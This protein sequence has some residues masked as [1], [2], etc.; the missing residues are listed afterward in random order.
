MKELIAILIWMSG[1][2]GAFG[3]N[4]DKM[5]AEIYTFGEYL[6]ACQPFEQS[7]SR[8]YTRGVIGLSD[9]VCSIYEDYPGPQIMRCAVPEA[10]LEKVAAVWNRTAKQIQDDGSVRMSY[11]SSDTETWNAFINSPACEFTEEK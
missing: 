6:R 5:R 10:D 9:G 4:P 11:D 2:F 7:I 3:P 8:S 1:G